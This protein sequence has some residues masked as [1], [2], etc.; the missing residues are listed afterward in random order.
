MPDKPNNSGRV[1]SINV[2]DGGVPKLPVP[3]AHITRDGVAGDRQRD[4]RHHGGPE[5]AVSLFSLEVIHRLQQEGHPISPGAAGENLTIT[6]LDWPSL[7]PGARLTFSGG[8]VLELASYCAPCKTIREAFTENN[9][10]RINQKTNPGE[11]R[12]YARVIHEGAITTNET[13]TVKS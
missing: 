12:L 9:F 4:L 10:G 2:S 5:R 7:T 1:V 8:V 6:G 3:A 11:S 13:I